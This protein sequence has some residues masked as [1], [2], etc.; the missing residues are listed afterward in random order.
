MILKLAFM[1][2][3]PVYVLIAYLTRDQ[4]ATADPAMVVTMSRILAAIFAIGIVMAPIVAR[5]SAK[6]LQDPNS[7]E[8]R[9]VRFILK[10]AF[11]ESGAIYGLV[12]S[13]MSRDPM[14]TVYFGI[15]ALLCL[16]LTPL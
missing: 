7:Q 12:L 11:Y 14:Y 13:L 1:A 5:N 9:N 3:I 15:P 2:S 4:P 16:L 10:A 6:N 8:A